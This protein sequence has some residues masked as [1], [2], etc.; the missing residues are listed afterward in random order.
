[1]LSLGCGAVIILVGGKKVPPS[2]WQFL[3]TGKKFSINCPKSCHILRQPEAFCNGFGKKNIV[4]YTFE[5]FHPILDRRYNFPF[6]CSRLSIHI[7]TQL[8]SYSHQKSV[9]TFHFYSHLSIPI[10][11]SLFLFTPHFFYS[12][13]T[14]LVPRSTVHFFSAILQFS[15]AGATVRLPCGANGRW[16]W[17]DR[18][19]RS[20]PLTTVLVVAWMPQTCFVTWLQKPRG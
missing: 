3:L 9:T 13:L 15:S 20:N 1:M 18:S 2:P 7:H 11:T 19:N 8:H 12:H 16:A 14:F 6:S 17:L 4:R 10:H 5:I